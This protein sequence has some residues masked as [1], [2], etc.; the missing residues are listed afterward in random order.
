[1][2]DIKNQGKI[3]ASEF[4]NAVRSI[5][6]N[7]SEAEVKKMVQIADKKGE[8]IVHKKFCFVFLRVS[9][10]LERPCES[11]IRIIKKKKN[12]K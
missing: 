6:H 11:Q 4:G 9:I 2:F 5:G 3:A 8:R 10:I 12:L 7:P 1:M